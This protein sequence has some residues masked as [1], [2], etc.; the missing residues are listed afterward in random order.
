MMIELL[1]NKNN[2]SQAT[3]NLYQMES[4]LTQK[5]KLIQTLSS[6]ENP[7]PLAEWHT[8]SLFPFTINMKT[9]QVL[10]DPIT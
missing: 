6:P 9:M 2:R 4:A 10:S 5:W 1:I 8:K 3:Y 7:N